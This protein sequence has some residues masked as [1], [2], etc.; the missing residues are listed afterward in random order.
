MKNSTAVFIVGPTG[1]GKTDVAIQVAGSLNT[2][3]ISADSRQVYRELSTG[4][5]APGEKQLKRVKHHLVRHRSVREY[6]NASMYEAE[7]L[8]TMESLFVNH[9]VLVVAGGSGLYIRAICE[10]IDDIPAVDPELRETL[11]ERIKGEGIESLRYELK[12]LDPES[13]RSIDLRNP[14]RVLKALEVSL[15]T[16]KPYSSYL[17]RQKKERDFLI[18]KIGLNLERDVLY[19]RINQR[20]DKMMENGL[21]DEVRNCLEYRD[22][23]ALNTVGYKELFEHLD[24][25]LSEQEAVHLIKRNSRRYARR[26]LTWFNGDPDI[27]WFSPDQTDEI[28]KH[29]NDVTGHKK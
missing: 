17:T 9:T 23:N 26:Q 14:K 28:I 22:L 10:G 11:L 1:V 15:S 21:L 13:Y 7:A 20:V 29:I 6:Y 2:E 27:T 24:G 8:G 25:R 3:I 5:A 12:K 16:G 18:L 19:D 4:T